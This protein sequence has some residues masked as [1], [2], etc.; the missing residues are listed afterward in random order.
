MSSSDEKPPGGG[1]PRAIGEEARFDSAGRPQRKAM[2]VIYL[3]YRTPTGRVGHRNVPSDQLHAVIAR[4][5]RK[6]YTS[7]R[8]L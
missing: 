4:L 3:M 6:G 2:H 5:T 7:F 8:A 1:P